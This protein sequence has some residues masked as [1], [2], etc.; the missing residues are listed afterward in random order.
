MPTILDHIVESTRSLVAARRREIPARELESLP[1]YFRTPTSLVEALR[2][3]GTPSD[4]LR[5]IAECKKASPS[6]GIIRAEYDPAAHAQ[7]YEAAGA[8]AVSV[9]TEPAFFQGSLEHLAAARPRVG[10]PLLRKDFVV[11]PYQLVEA[12]AYGADAVLLIASVLDRNE[13]ADLHAAAEALGLSCLVECYEESE[14][15]KLDFAQVR[16]VGVNNRNLH[17]FEV[18]RSHA[19]RVLAR[20][21]DPIVRIAESGLRTA[22]DFAAMRRA[23]L[24]AVLVGEAFMRA[25]DPGEALARLRA[26]TDRLIDSI[27][28]S[29]H[30]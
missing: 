8:A 25:P 1:G 27:T 12:R 14:L 19:A 2:P 7:A 17:T 13:L 15:D 5:F 18:D 21:P 29:V 23:G 28:G 16:I 11:D 10:L 22:A 9:L 24:D 6:K 30:P 4:E 3:G 26:E 20:V